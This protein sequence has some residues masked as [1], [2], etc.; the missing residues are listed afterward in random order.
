MKKKRSLLFMVLFILFTSIN[1]AQGDGRSFDNSSTNARDTI[2]FEEAKKSLFDGNWVFEVSK[3]SVSRKPSTLVVGPTHF[4]LNKRDSCYVL[5]Y[6]LL[7]EGPSEVSGS[8][9]Y[10]I[11]KCNTEIISVKEGKK[12]EIFQEMKIKGINLKAEVYIT[13]V[14]K[15]NMAYAEIY[16]IDAKK[17][18]KVYY[19]GRVIPLT[20]S[21][22]IDIEW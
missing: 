13:L 6:S 17:S 3:I 18:F 22:Y 4:I 19:T 20:D 12:G 10:N 5:L 21:E 2:S 14:G 15:D 7:Y 16:K 8:N 11:C 9:G 1:F